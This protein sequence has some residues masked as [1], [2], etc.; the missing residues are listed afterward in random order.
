MSK[1]RNH[2]PEFEAKVTLEASEGERTV[3]E[4]ASEFRVHPTMIHSWKRALLKGASGLFQTRREKA[5]RD[6]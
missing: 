6:R 1:W 4:P 2:S 5:A 3:A